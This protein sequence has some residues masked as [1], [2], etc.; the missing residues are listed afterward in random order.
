[1]RTPAARATLGRK[2]RTQ[3]PGVMVAWQGLLPEIDS[4]TLRVCGAPPGKAERPT[5]FSAK[6]ESGCNLTA[7]ENVMRGPCA[8][9]RLVPF[10][11]A[12][13]QPTA[14]IVARAETRGRHGSRKR[15]P[16]R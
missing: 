14:P 13:C 4:D 5:R 6:A 7:R 3:V 15:S 8:T 16:T 12:P 2:K 11:K 1:M 10:W 9:V